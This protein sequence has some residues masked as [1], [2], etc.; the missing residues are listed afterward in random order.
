[1]RLVSYSDA[2]GFLTRTQRWLEKDE[3]STSLMLGVALRLQQY[4]ERIRARPYYATVDDDQGLALAAMMTPP[5]RLIVYGERPDV[6]EA[7]AS[8]L[9]DLVAGGWPVPGVL[10]PRPVAAQAAAQWT[11]ITG[12]AYRLGR[13]ERIYALRHV[14]PLVPA[15][16][17]LR[18]ATVDDLALTAEWTYAF[19]DEA[20]E[21]ADRESALETTAQRIT[22]GHLWVWDDGGPVSMCASV[23]PVAHSISV[24]LVYTPP[25]LRRRGYARSAVAALSHIMLDKGWELCTLF[26]DLA[27]PTSNH[28]YQE[29]GYVPICDYD[30]YTFEP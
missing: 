13:G 15:P 2:G 21:P 4:P 28:I 5:Y 12:R 14:N 24:S 18:P 8:V 20:G 29:I 6:T 19:Q 10:G 3:A 26:A 16:G 1:M 22:D 7:L 17:R 30:E 27:N 11:E 23:R 25:R 9:Q